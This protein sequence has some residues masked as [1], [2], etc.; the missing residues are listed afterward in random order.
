MA[1]DGGLG[2]VAQESARP[3]PRAGEGQ[4]VRVVVD[5]AGGDLPVPERLVTDQ[6]LQEGDVGGDSADAELAQRTSHPV[7]GAFA[8]RPPGG[9]LLQ[10]RVVVPGDDR[11]G[12]RGA[13][14]E[15]DA[16]AGR[17]PVGGDAAVV[18]D[19]AVE[20]VLGGDPALY[21]VAA[22]RQGILRRAGRIRPVAD[23]AALGDA[24]LGPHQIDPGDLLGDRVFD[25][26][27]GVDL[28]EVEAAGVDVVQELDGSGVE[29]V[30]LAR[31]GERV[32]GQCF[33]LPGG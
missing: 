24:D 1:V 7:D 6:P 26:D 21:G 3:V 25:L 10:Q 9:D 27:A 18:G 28:D 19:E 30:G 16:E 14:V 29:V 12:V 23:G 32:S 5:E 4:Q 8:R 31:D 20:R 22:Q 33:A 15:P 17:G 2:D 13:A 11:A